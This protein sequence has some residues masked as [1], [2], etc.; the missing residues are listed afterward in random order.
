[1]AVSAIKKAVTG[2]IGDKIYDF[3]HGRGEEEAMKK[4]FQKGDKAKK[5]G[6]MK[7]KPKKPTKKVPRVKRKTMPQAEKKMAKPAEEKKMTRAKKK[8]SK[9]SRIKRATPRDKDYSFDNPGAVERRGKGISSL[10]D[11]YYK[12]EDTMRGMG[13]N[14]TQEQKVNFSRMKD[15]YFRKRKETLQSPDYETKSGREP[16][17]VKKK[18]KKK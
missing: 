13:K 2:G 6:M 5:K 9:Y 1:M 11:D 12:L 7:K 10:R 3:L 16:F 8:P 18:K 14:P 15:A 4:N 17:S